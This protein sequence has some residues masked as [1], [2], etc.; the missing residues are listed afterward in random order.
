MSL[1]NGKIISDLSIFENPEKIKFEN[2]TLEQNP[3]GIIR[4][5]NNKIVD[6]L[7][8]EKGF[9]S[10]LI[11][12]II[13]KTN[14]DVYITTLGGGISILKKNNSKISF[15]NKNINVKDIICSNEKKIC[16]F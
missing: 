7:T 11:S 1:T 16:N 9:A 2:F 12:D 6:T 15:L 14:G 13:K 4:K 5:E 8:E 3:L 10:N